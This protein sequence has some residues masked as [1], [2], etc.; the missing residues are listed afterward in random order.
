MKMMN[1]NTENVKRWRAE[2]PGKWSEAHQRQNRV[3]YER[4]R[5]KLKKY[6]RDK[7]AFKSEAKKFMNILL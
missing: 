1:T 4:H 5:E 3:Y 6:Y 2:N 7:N